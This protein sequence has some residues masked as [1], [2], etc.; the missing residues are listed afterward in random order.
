MGLLSKDMSL[1]PWQ[2][3]VT[4]D[5]HWPLAADKETIFL[6]PLSLLM[7]IYPKKSSNKRKKS[8]S[9]GRSIISFETN[10]AAAAAAARG[11]HTGFWESCFCFTLRQANVSTVFLPSLP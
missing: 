3:K 7:V 8:R 2:N 6:D 11:I 10:Q 4:N 5:P 9:V 1:G